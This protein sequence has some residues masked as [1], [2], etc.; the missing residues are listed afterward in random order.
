MTGLSFDPA[1]FGLMHKHPGPVPVGSQ[2]GCEPGQSA[3]FVQWGRVAGVLGPG[4]HKLDPQAVPFLSI[5]V[6]Q[7]PEGAMLG[8]E[9]YIL[10]DNVLDVRVAPASK[11]SG[12]SGAEASPKLTVGVSVRI[13][14][15]AQLLARLAGPA[16]PGVVERVVADALANALG[17]ALAQ[18][19]PR[20]LSDPA[21]CRAAV[22][23]ALGA[24][25]EQ[26][27]AMAIEVLGVTNVV[28]TLPEDAR[29]RPA[30]ATTPLAAVADVAAA[31]PAAAAAPAPAPA[32]AAAPAAAA[33]AGLAV[34]ARVRISHGGIWH[35]GNIVELQDA[36]AEIAWDGAETKTWLPVAQL[37]PEPSYPGAHPSGTRVLAQAPDGG[38]QPGSVR[39]FNGTSYQIAFEGG[40][41]AWLAPGQ[42]KLA[43]A[44]S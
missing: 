19:S 26:L 18:K 37:E 27:R 21:A 29:A 39:H 4:T 3:V 8:G 17:P 22:D 31:T 10:Q 9:L 12:G 38:F 25:R 1:S 40:T 2:L 14:D 16:E 34:G 36:R 7:R 13:A 42:I 5:M 6:E 20:E 23:A 15:P 35:S 44:A 28:A 41:T 33:P 43:P 11:Q 32:P 30:V 24:A